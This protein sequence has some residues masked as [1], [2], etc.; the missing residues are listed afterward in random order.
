MKLKIHGKQS[1][2]TLAKFLLYIQV[3]FSPH[4]LTFFVP[5]HWMCA[6]HNSRKCLLSMHEK[7]FYYLHVFAWAGIVS[8]NSYTKQARFY[9]WKTFS[10]GSIKPFSQLPW[11]FWY[12]PP[13]FFLVPYIVSRLHKI[14]QGTE[15]IVNIFPFIK[16][17]RCIDKF[18]SL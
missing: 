2:C 1:S 16:S 13:V 6:L 8:K 14:G 10:F 4:T 5:V 17:I 7:A 11:P 12:F 3:L 9:T 18:K 15:G